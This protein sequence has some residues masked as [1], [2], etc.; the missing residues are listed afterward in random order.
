MSSQRMANTNCLEGIR[1]PIPTCMSE[2]SF[3]IEVTGWVQVTDEGWTEI[4]QDCDWS[5]DSYIRCESCGHAATVAHF[6]IPS[7]PPENHD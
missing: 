7:S 6:R 3:V 5:D 2:D 4:P 1:C